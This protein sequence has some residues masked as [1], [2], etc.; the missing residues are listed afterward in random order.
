MSSELIE[1]EENSDGQD[2]TL[3]MKANNNAWLTILGRGIE[4]YHLTPTPEG[5]Y[6]AQSIIKGLQEWINHINGNFPPDML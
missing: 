2:I 3:E 1:L 5:I 6:Q 4:K